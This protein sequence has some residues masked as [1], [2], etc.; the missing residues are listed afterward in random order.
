MVLHP[1]FLRIKSLFQ[2]PKVEREFAEELEFHQ[3]LAALQVRRRLRS[4]R[5]GQYCV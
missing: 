4:T 3:E 5:C 1:F 2:R